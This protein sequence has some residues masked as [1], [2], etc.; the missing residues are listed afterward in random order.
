MATTFE[1]NLTLIARHQLTP[2]VFQLDFQRN[3][4]F[5]FKPGHFISLVIPKAGPNGRDLRRAYSI[6]SAPESDQLDLCVKKV[7]GGPGTSY[8]DSL[9]VGDTIKG[10]APFGDFVD[11]S[12]DD[13]GKVWIAT[14][15]GISPF[16]SMLFSDLAKKKDLSK[17]H[18]L[19]GVREPEEVIYHGLFEE[20]LGNRFKMAVS[21][22]HSG[23]HGYR[24]RVTDILRSGDLH[25]DYANTD[26]YLCGNGAMIDEVLSI[27]A[28][29][30]VEKKAIHKEAYY[31]PKPGE[32]HAS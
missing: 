16:R 4:L 1:V 6:A 26:F 19:F 10:N 22:P 28:E 31:K 17:T 29:K 30:Q 14:G 25:L 32:T 23:F 13:R 2:T 20:H 11:K 24:G 3:P 5:D 18:C 7:D 21:R 27:L 15:T 8:L 12:A 9:K